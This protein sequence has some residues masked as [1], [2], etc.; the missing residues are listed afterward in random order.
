MLQE[1]IKKFI[2][3]YPTLYNIV[4]IL[5]GFQA[6][7]I[8]HHVNPIPRYGS[9]KPPHSILYNIINKGR[10]NYKNTLNIFQS[11]KED[12][13]QIPVKKQDDT[14]EPCWNNDYIPGLDLVA[15]YSF[16]CLKKPKRYFEVGSGNSTKIAKHA[17]GN[18]NLSIKITSIDPSPRANIDIICDTIIRIPLEKVNLQIFD[19][20][21]END[22]L[23]I[24]S[25]HRC[26]MN[27]DVTVVFLD[28]LPKLKPGILVEFHDIFLPYDYSQEW[29]VYY[30]SEQYLLAA[31]ILANG[32]RF[33][34]VL[35]N[36]FICN[37]SELSHILDPLWHNPKLESA[38]NFGAS[39]WIITK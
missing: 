31:Y 9:G 27:S 35:P 37:D 22:I 13:L 7:V 21:E 29:A 26:F 1:K 34:I 4:G 25:S 17:I 8:E 18:H 28:I 20:L 23:Y 16:L 10:N 36:C 6:L 33:D 14:Q 3:K 38:N 19:E 30:Y 24:D 32:N 39:F 5:S 2:K 15:L 11:L 12:F